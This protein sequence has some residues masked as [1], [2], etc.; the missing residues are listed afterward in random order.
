MYSRFDE[1]VPKYTILY[2]FFFIFEKI[3]HFLQNSKNVYQILISCF[4]KLRRFSVFS[5][6][7]ASY[8][9]VSHPQYSVSLQDETSETNPFLRYFA[10]LIFASV[11]L[12]FASK[13]NVGTPYECPLPL[14][15]SAV[16]EGEVARYQKFLP[17]NLK[18]LRKK[19]RFLSTY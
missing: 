4:A 1:R 18:G 9:F 3:I 13:R 11:S 14:A 6:F 5:V 7:F 2:N 8:H 17:N 12:R 15:F 16:W 10:S 19:Q